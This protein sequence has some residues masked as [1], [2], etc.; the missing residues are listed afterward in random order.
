MLVSNL[1]VEADAALLAAPRRD[2]GHNQENVTHEDW[3][4]QVSIDLLHDNV[5]VPRV[6]ETRLKEAGHAGKHESFRRN[7][8]TPARAL[9]V[10][11]VV[12]LWLDGRADARDPADISVRD[13]CLEREFLPCREHVCRRHARLSAKCSRQLRANEN[14]MTSI[15]RLIARCIAPKRTGGTHRSMRLNALAGA[16][17]VTADHTATGSAH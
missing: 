7:R 13:R 4:E 8:P 15:V 2:T 16:A 9:G 5:A 10:P 6:D 14:S 17:S 11:R 1:N 12:I 3:P